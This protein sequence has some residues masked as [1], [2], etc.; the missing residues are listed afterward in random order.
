MPKFPSLGRG[1]PILSKKQMFGRNDDGFHFRNIDFEVMAKTSE[2]SIQKNS[3]NE[4]LQL[5]KNTVKLQVYI[6]QHIV[7]YFKTMIA[8][9]VAIGKRVRKRTL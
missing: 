1:A 7:N 6:H 9:E 3:G 5:K 8:N 4:D 2:W